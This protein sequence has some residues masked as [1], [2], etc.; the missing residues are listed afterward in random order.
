[1][2]LS[3][4]LRPA[5][6][7]T[8]DR[9][10][11]QPAQDRRSRLRAVVPVRARRGR[12]PAGDRADGAPARRL[13]RPRRAD[14][15]ADRHRLAR[16][17]HPG[18]AD[19]DALRRALGDRRRRRVGRAGDGALPVRLEPVGVRRRR[20]HGRH[21]GRRL[22]PRAAELSH[23]GGAVPLP[24]PRPLDARRRDAHRPV[25]RPVSRRRADPRDG[26]R[27]RVLGRHRR[28]RA[29]RGGRRAHPRAAGARDGRCRQRRRGRARA[30]DAALGRQPATRRSF[31]PSASA[32]CSSPRCAP[33]ARR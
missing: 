26:H 7:P 14:G 12:D 6:L 2:R 29:R 30:G 19:H 22:R 27:R 21:V 4:L 15:D 11:L 10:H 23:R 20:L 9:R 17:Q 18:L 33:R 32:R 8:R 28:A 5:A 25:P 24:R 13:G 31:S 16:L 1:M 3:S